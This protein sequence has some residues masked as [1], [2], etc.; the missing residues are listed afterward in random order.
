ML[1]LVYDTETTGLPSKKKDAKLS[2]MPYI[3]QLA[4]ILYNGARPVAHFSSYLEP[5]I[6]GEGRETPDV[7]FFVDAGLTKEAMSPSR[8]SSQNG[9]AAFHKLVEKADRTVAHNERFDGARIADTYTRL[10]GGVHP[11]WG[12]TPHY[13][14]MLTLEPIMKLP[15]KWG[16]GYKWPNMDEAYRAYVDTDGFDGAHDAMNDV[17]ATAEV[18]FA[19][20]RMSISLIRV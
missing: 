4:C 1:T 8:L 15:A 10:T 12:A 14:T 9:I 17:Q 5:F 3:V 18:M 16:K 7:K 6:N 11:E 20:E 13:C 19:I 2:D